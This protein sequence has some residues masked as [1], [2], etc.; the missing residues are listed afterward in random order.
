M[1]PTLLLLRRS[2]PRRLSIEP[3][4]D[5]RFYASTYGRFLTPD[6]YQASA[7]GANNPSD[8]GSWNRYAYVNGDPVNL[9]DP[10]GM[11]A[12]LPGAGRGVTPKTVVL[13]WA[14]LVR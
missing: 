4:P 9:I 1:S 7:K 2:V 14:A 3:R 11:V 5:Q 8:P 10:S 6:P 13:L 12:S